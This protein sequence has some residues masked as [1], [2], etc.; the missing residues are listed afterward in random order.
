MFVLLRWRCRTRR[1]PTEPAK[2]PTPSSTAA[3]RTSIWRIW[4]PS[5]EVFSCPRLM[6]CRVRLQFVVTYQMDSRRQKFCIIYQLYLTINIFYVDPK[7]WNEIYSTYTNTELLAYSICKT[8][9]PIVHVL[10]VTIHTFCFFWV[11]VCLKSSTER[12]Y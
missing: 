6:P 3:K 2:T 9:G 1:R 7:Q 4:A 11:R 8:F 10:L 12:A 5:L